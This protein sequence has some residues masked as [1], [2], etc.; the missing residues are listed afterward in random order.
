MPEGN[1]PR[2]KVPTTPQDVAGPEDVWSQ[3]FGDESEQQYFLTDVRARHLAVLQQ[4]GETFFWLQRKLSGTKCPF[5]SDESQQCRDPLNAESACYN[6]KYIG[7]YEMPLAIK[8]GLPT[9][10]RQTVAEEAGLL[11][12]QPMRPWTIWTP[13]LTDRD[14]LVRSTSG[15][16]FEILNVQESG[17]WRGL[18]MAQ[19]FDMRPMQVGVDFAYNL[20]V[21]PPGPGR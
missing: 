18:V 5:W 13:R 19:F 6:A 15:E 10:V 17:P 1:T 3:Y 8:V 4:D 7:G 21:T 20:T 12:S 11:K 2:P 9:A 16:R 14:M